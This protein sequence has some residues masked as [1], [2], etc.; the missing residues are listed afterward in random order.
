MV[1]RLL[2]L[3]DRT[4]CVGGLPATVARAV[5][6][7]ARAVVVRERDLPGPARADLIG[8]LRAVLDPVGGV[9]I[10][11]GPTGDAV[12]LSATEPF[13]SERPKLVGRSCHDAG[14]VVQAGADGCDYITVS[15]VFPTAS[16]PDY[17]PPLGLT[18]LAQLAGPA[19]SKVYA[20]GGVLPWHVPRCL[21]VGVYGIAVMG[22]V[23]RDPCIVIEYL[24]ALEASP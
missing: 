1:S 11:A 24:S 22:P 7:G 8:A 20:L 14:E 16:K 18:G 23:M 17:G 21:T 6:H 3:T 13:P 2:V 9:L 15:P 10:V 12:H 19:V 5:D 4:R